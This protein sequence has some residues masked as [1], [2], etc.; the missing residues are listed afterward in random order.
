MLASLAIVQKEKRKRKCKLP[1]FQN[2]DLY[3]YGFSANR[4]D[5][6]FLNPLVPLSVR[7]LNP[8]PGRR[9]LFSVSWRSSHFQ[10]KASERWDKWKTWPNPLPSGM[11]VP[12][13]FFVNM[14]NIWH[15]WRG[16]SCPHPTQCSN[17]WFPLGLAQLYLFLHPGLGAAFFL[18][19]MWMGNSS[20]KGAGSQSGC[21]CVAMYSGRPVAAGPF[22][23][24]QQ[25]CSSA[26]LFYW[27]VVYLGYLVPLPW[28]T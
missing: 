4:W 22:I 10:V 15:H 13:T 26:K 14:G 23:R 25:Q 11:Y 12:H 27:C 9:F 19:D 8:H 21:E 18:S 7:N 6:P 1:G 16:Y 17:W 3:T 2:V 20:R 28:C 24:Q 5:P